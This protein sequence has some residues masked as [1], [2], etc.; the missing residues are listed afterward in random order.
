M[1]QQLL[2]MKKI[3]GIYNR[4]ECFLIPGVG[5]WHFNVVLNIAD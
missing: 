2:P 5:C 1:G 4:L 3:T